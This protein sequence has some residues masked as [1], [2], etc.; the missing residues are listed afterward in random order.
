MNPVEDHPAEHGATRVVVGAVY[1]HAVE[2]DTEQD[3]HSADDERGLLVPVQIVEAGHIVPPAAIAEIAARRV[4][5]DA[6]VLRGRDAELAQ[7]AQVQ[8]H[9]ATVAAEN[10]FRLTCAEAEP[11]LWR[12]EADALRVGGDADAQHPGGDD[13]D[14]L[15]QGDDE[16][17]DADRLGAAAQAAAAAAAQSHPRC[18]R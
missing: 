7:L 12:V 11:A 10:R 4:Q 9:I 16:E 5:R 2:A 13:A 8:L 3:V 15:Q 6:A 17:E 14:Q 1:Q 18:R